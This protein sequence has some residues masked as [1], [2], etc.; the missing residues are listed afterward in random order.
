MSN[1][2]MQ[3]GHKLPLL[4]RDRDAD[5][6]SFDIVASHGEGVMVK[7]TDGAI[8][9]GHFRDGKRNGLGTLTDCEGTQYT[10][11]WTDNKREGRGEELFVDGS[12]FIGHYVDDKKCGH[13]IFKCRSGEYSGQWE[14]DE[15]HGEGAMKGVDVY[16]YLGQF[17]R[18]FATGQGSESE[19]DWIWTY[20]GQF[21]AGRRH[22]RG[23]MKWGDNREYSF[24]GL[25]TNDEFL[26]QT[27]ALEGGTRL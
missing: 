8:Y 1:H 10:A 18:G 27:P 6:K 26:A 21:E 3:R 4:S 15:P 13:G 9:Q 22:G 25:W 14:R 19:R 7:Y 2:I 12:T 20:S 11:N 17:V 5:W 16:L 24:D 23:T